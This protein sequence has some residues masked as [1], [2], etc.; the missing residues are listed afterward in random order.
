[1]AG[2]FEQ[3]REAR[4]VGRAA[5]VPDVQ[6]ARG[7]GGDELD[8]D[9]LRLRRPAA[10]EIRA[11]RERARDDFAFGVR[12]EPEIHEAGSGDVRPLDPLRDRWGQR[13]RAL[14]KRI[15]E[16]ARIALELLRELQRE[17]AR[18]IAV[19][20]LPRPLEHDREACEFGRFLLQRLAQRRRHCVLGILSH[21]EE[22]AD[23]KP[24]GQSNSIGST[25]MCQRTCFGGA[26][27][28]ASL[29]P[30]R[31][32]CSAGRE[33]DWMSSCARSSPARRVITLGTG[34]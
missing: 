24:R 12:L 18:K 33:A 19:L 11:F 32:S 5:P 1:M 10:P 8:L 16:I 14:G 28:S 25:S 29:R 22:G 7:I 17:R 3:A 13:Q 21:G 2:E 9:F 31:C 6:R 4:A 15:R 30:R 34:S 26:A 23:Y 20:R 27:N